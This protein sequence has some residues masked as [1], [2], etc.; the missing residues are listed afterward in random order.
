M[1]SFSPAALIGHR[2]QKA[3]KQKGTVKQKGAAY[4]DKRPYGLPDLNAWGMAL[5]ERGRLAEALGVYGRALAAAPRPSVVAEGGPAPAPPPPRGR[6]RVPAPA[7]HRT[8][9]PT[10]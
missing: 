10:R 8:V 6:S 5:D 2:R 4:L 9:E 1:A 7:A 3:G